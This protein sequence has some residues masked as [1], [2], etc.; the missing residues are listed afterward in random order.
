VIS[1]RP[2]LD[3]TETETSFQSLLV[4][5]PDAIVIADDAGRIVLVNKQAEQ[6]FGYDRAD[7]LGQPVEVLLPARL[8]SEHTRSRDR[9][10][11][12]PHPRPMGSGLDLVA[13]RQDGSEFPVE[14]SLSP[15]WS[16]GGSLIIN[17]IRDGVK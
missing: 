1:L 17:A 14:I 12:A 7:L 2:E 9:Y 8:R 11:A 6:L 4:S 3:H 5:A 16:D 13:R 15:L 10:G